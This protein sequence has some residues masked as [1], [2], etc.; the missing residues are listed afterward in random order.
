M[1]EV[2]KPTLTSIQGGL[3]ASK[4]DRAFA[5]AERLWVDVL[6]C[7]DTWKKWAP[8]TLRGVLAPDQFLAVVLWALQTSNTTEADEKLIVT[9]WGRALVDACSKRLITALHPVCLL[10]LE[11]GDPPEE[12]VLTLEDAQTFLDSMPL[13]FSLAKSLAWWCEQAEK[14]ESRDQTLE[15]VAA[16]RT[17]VKGTRW[18]DADKQ[19][20]AEA[21]SE[22]GIK[23]VAAVLGL[24]EFAVRNVIKGYAPSQ[25]TANKVRPKAMPWGSTLVARS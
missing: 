24:R 15:E 23:E 4:N 16:R 19:V 8:G 9:R 18:T 22:K 3:S 20:V 7:L 2:D 11:H 1:D 6:G 14:L 17:S 21:V 25:S 5:E 10:P 13:G 12:W